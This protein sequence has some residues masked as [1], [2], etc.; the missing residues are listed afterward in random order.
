[1]T[2]AR[3]I[4]DRIRRSIEYA[5]GKITT[6]SGGWVF[7]PTETQTQEEI[8]RAGTLHESTDDTGRAMYLVLQRSTRCSNPGMSTNRPQIEGQWC[9][10][11]KTCRR[12]QHYRKG[13]DDGLRYPHCDWARAQRGGTR[14]GRARA[15]KDLNKAAKEAAEITGKL[16]R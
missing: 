14:A 6:L 15:L 13:G 12:C 2:L 4:S 8:S 1:M 5:N 7:Q 16:P 3:L 9:V 11:I 10:P